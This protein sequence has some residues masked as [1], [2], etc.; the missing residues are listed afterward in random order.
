MLDDAG[1]TW[2]SRTLGSGR[3]ENSQ[4]IVDLAATSVTLSGNIATLTVGIEFKPAFRGDKSVYMFAQSVTGLATGWVTR[5]SWSVPGSLTSPEVTAVSA[6][7]S[8]GSGT[9]QTFVLQYSDNLGAA[10]L[11]SARVRFGTTETSGANNCTVR[12]APATS[13][14]SM[15]NDAGTAWLAGALGAGVLRNSQCTIDLRNSSITLSGPVLSMRLAVTFSAAF[16]G[17]KNI[18]LLAES[19]GG[20]STGWVRR[21]AWTVP[22]S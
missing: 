16:A 6:S 2:I 4:C 5:G 9:A 21:G 15:L 3:L 12:Y 1:A 10:D 18:Y 20:Q 19:S 7:P 17:A 22:G 13:T 14:V 11:A 8:A